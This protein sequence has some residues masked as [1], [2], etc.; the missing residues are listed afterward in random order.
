MQR[1]CARN[2]ARVA[3]R[4]RAGGAGTRA[5]VRACVRAFA[6]PGAAHWRCKI[7]ALQNRSRRL[8]LILA[9]ASV[10][11]AAMEERGCH[12]R[13]RMRTRGPARAHAHAGACRRHRPA[14]PIPPPGASTHTHPSAASFKSAGT[15][16][17]RESRGLGTSLSRR[18]VERCVNMNKGGHS[19]SSSDGDRQAQARLDGNEMPALDLRR[20]LPR[21]RL[22]LLL[23]F[24]PQGS[25]SLDR[26]A[27]LLHAPQAPWACR[28]SVTSMLWGW[29]TCSLRRRRRPS[30]V[31]ASGSASMT[32]GG[33]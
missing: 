9:A 18:L 11:S 8:S 30:E 15:E 22:A 20:R 27:L 24:A 6:G 33:P 31:P 32:S 7:A 5:A 12:S 10:G 21:D 1:R 16:R 13:P 23:S 29:P 3:A 26:L 14:P 2:D 28:L 4:F 17:E 19:W 25:G